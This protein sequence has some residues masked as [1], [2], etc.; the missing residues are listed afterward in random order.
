MK[1]LRER[2]RV[3]QRKD[4]PGN[5][6]SYTTKVEEMSV[7]EFREQGYLQELNRRFLHPLGLALEVDKGEDGEEKFSKIWDYRKDKDGIVFPFKETLQFDF[8]Q[9]AKK[10][11]R[12]I[13]S[14][15]KWRRKRLGFFVQPI[16][17]EGPK[18]KLKDKKD[19]DNGSDG[20]SQKSD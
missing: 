9:K 2:E 11:N 6:I 3:I 18:Y 16:A 1:D 4:V 8:Y 20:D 13:K 19:G 15:A 14:K 7:K 12:E 10:I 5:P 17:Y